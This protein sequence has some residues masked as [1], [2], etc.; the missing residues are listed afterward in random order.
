MKQVKKHKY[1]VTKATPPLHNNFQPSGFSGNI[2]Q[3]GGPSMQLS[4]IFEPE[5]LEMP[6]VNDRTKSLIINGCEN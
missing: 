2:Q 5:D 6:T 3:I 1:S 4:S